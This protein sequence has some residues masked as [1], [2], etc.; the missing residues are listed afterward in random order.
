MEINGM[1]RCLVD[2]RSERYGGFG[3]DFVETRRVSTKE[4]IILNSDEFCLQEKLAKNPLE[5]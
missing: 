2:I 5:K 3:S 4:Q 1:K